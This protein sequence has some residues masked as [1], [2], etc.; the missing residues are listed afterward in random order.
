MK[1]NFKLRHLDILAN[2]DKSKA[3]L[4]T[5]MVEIL[6]YKNSFFGKTKWFVKNFMR[7]SEM[8]AEAQ[9]ITM[10]DV[11]FNEDFHIKRPSTVNNISYVQMLNLQQATKTADDDGLSEHIAKVVSIA[12]Y[13][14]NRATPYD[15]NGQVYTQ[16]K[17]ELLNEPLFDML[18][19]YNWI[20]E[21][22]TKTSKEWEKLF[23]SVE[24][25]DKDFQKHGGAGM[26]QFNVINTIKGICSDFNY[27][28]K[29]AWMVSYYLVMM[30][31]YSK[32]YSTWVQNN[33]RE[34][35]EAEMLRNRQ[36]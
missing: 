29:E 27:N 14:S 21:D 30:N 4:S 8:V 25:I 18:G 9:S 28:E 24:V 3:D 31:N 33:I 6:G 7:M 10:D 17:K 12:T 5:L 36:T 20:I 19:L 13:D 26:S 34:A 23:F 35:K 16:Y 32:A 22:L 2:D 1:N 11:K 15:L